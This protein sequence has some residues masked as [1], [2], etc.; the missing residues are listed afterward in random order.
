MS[1][2]CRLPPIKTFLAILSMTLAAVPF[3]VATTTFYVNGGS[4]N[5]SWDGL[6]PDWDG[7][8]GPK[9]T[10]QA[11]IN[12]TV[13]GDTITIA[14][15]PYSGPGN[16][17]LSNQGKYLI[18][19][20]VTNPSPPQVDCSAT[21]TFMTV[22]GYAVTIQGLTI[23]NAT[24]TSV[25]AVVDGS[26]IT[27]STYD[28]C[29]KSCTIV[30]SRCAV[31]GSATGY[32]MPNTLRTKIDSCTFASNSIMLWLPASKLVITNSTITCSVP[33]V[34][35]SR[36]N[37]I[38]MNQKS[39]FDDAYE[40]E[41]IIDG[42][43]FSFLLTTNKYAPLFIDS[44]HAY[45]RNS[46]FL[47]NSNLYRD[48]GAI[49]WQYTPS[50]GDAGIALSNCVFDGN[51][52]TRNG[53]A[54]YAY[55]PQITDCRFVGNT[56][57]SDG[58]AVY[59]S[60]STMERSIFLRNKAAGSGAAIM[61][62]GG[63]DV[64]LVKNCLF[65][66]NVCSGRGSALYKQ[67]RSTLAF[68]NTTFVNNISTNAGDLIAGSV[69]RGPERVVGMTMKNS[70]VWQNTTNTMNALFGTLNTADI[71][72]SLVD[73]TNDI[74]AANNINTDPK[75][76]SS[77]NSDYHLKSHAGHWTTNGWVQ[78]IVTSPCIDAGDPTSD[79]GNE[80]PP[81]GGR[82]NM[83]C[84]GNTAQASR[85][86][87]WTKIVQLVVRG[88]PLN[89]GISDP[90]DYGTNLVFIG[91]QVTNSV[92]RLF[93][94]TN[95]GVRLNC[96]GWSG[97]NDIPTTGNT[98]VVVFTATTNS[99]MTW[100]WQTQY[101]MTATAIT[102]GT[103]TPTSAW[104]QAGSTSIVTA[105]PNTGYHFAGWTGDVPG[106]QTNNSPVSLTMNQA[107]TIAANFAINVYTLTVVSAHSG[108]MPG[109]TVTNWNTE[110]SCY[111]TNSPV[112]SG[113]TQYV[114]N[115]GAV[116]SNSFS[117]VDATNI[118]LTLTNNA[119]LTW[120]WRTQYWLHPTA[121]PNGTLDQPDQ[122]VDSGS[123]VT[124]N[125][126][127]SNY[128]HFAA[129]SGNTNGCTST[130]NQI[131][132][133]MDRPRAIS[134]NFSANMA[135]NNTPHW[136]LA[137]YGLPT[138]DVG[139]LYDDGDGMPAWQEYVADTDPT[140]KD[141]V[142]SMIGIT[143]EVGSIRLDWKGGQWATQ[144]IQSRLD[145]GSTS[146]VWK[147][148]YTNAILPTPILNFVIDAVPTNSARF[149]RIKAER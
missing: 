131:T 56:A 132:A 14:S 101:M 104:Y 65:A 67:V 74:S 32:K 128:Y 146:D 121:G 43:T 26:Q 136:W 73:V 41:M 7:T 75:F 68:E 99:A 23:Q 35:G 57:S 8:H 88:S 58:G 30:N 129:W 114:A 109:T 139:A 117:Q 66:E 64:V 62:S 127:A 2:L 102:N 120:Q 115:G 18:V 103:V 54:V 149:Y 119:V 70:I 137:Q 91:D 78:D 6:G 69:I 77:S 33:D 108:Q 3:A 82:V 97:T 24:A 81:N 51:S 141:S 133:W 83:G 27:D 38:F 138:N 126:T 31:R 85:S 110:L 86:P 29:L 15:G 37:P 72:N 96:A 95:G 84:Y 89:Y 71:S 147:S 44:G 53:G 12:T 142:L 55:C 9:K 42:S 28:F 80:P 20:G 113:T 59:G 60:L 98:N 5:D 34:N 105:L 122:W 11:A 40:G 49:G 50:G 124:I 63:S 47:C 39:Y 21:N 76:C 130:G 123:N 140:N 92:P 143:Q 145:L 87:D 106:A 52:A 1:R 13:Q 93:A 118:T 111:L 94:G 116:L 107:R 46:T 90:C 112:M 22:S 61:G 25:V 45:I 100:L 4:G 16:I 79:Y 19:Q 144:Y 48:G 125:G 148:I 10:I 36:Y 134:A 17:N 135:T